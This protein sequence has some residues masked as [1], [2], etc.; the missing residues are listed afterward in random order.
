MR[1]GK[2]MKWGGV[3]LLASV[4]FGW[5][6]P[7]IIRSFDPDVRARLYTT[8]RAT[9]FSPLDFWG[10]FLLATLLFTLLYIW[11]WRRFSHQIRRGGG[12][13][14]RLPFSKKIIPIEEVR[15]L[16]EEKHPGDDNA[17]SQET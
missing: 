9:P 4:F 7:L 11:D 6:I 14:V 13:G 16:W 17:R 15:R 5:N 3:V 1:Y 8:V 10:G 12:G 2:V